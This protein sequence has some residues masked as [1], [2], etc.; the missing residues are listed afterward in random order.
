MGILIKYYE[1]TLDSKLK[2]L[3]FNVEMILSPVLSV[4]NDTL[5]S[6]CSFIECQN[7][8]PNNKLYRNLINAQSHIL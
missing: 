7:V 3:T 5:L 4:C 1:G 6:C 8:C 2:I